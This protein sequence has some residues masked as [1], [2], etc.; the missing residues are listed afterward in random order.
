MINTHDVAL[1]LNQLP[2]SGRAAPSVLEC[3]FGSRAE[4][5]TCWCR[6]DAWRCEASSAVQDRKHG[7]VTWRGDDD[8]TDDPRGAACAINSREVGTW[9]QVSKSPRSISKH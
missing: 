6:R 2:G 5:V 9:G 7:G 1:G 3:A 8:A 4:M